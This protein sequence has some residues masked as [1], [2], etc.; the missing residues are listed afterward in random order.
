MDG[1][2]LRNL[3][4][5]YILPV[6][7]EVPEADRD[8]VA[9][10]VAYHMV[11]AKHGDFTPFSIRLPAERGRIKHWY[12]VSK[13]T[14]TPLDVTEDLTD[15]KD[16]KRTPFTSVNPSPYSKAIWAKVYAKRNSN[17]I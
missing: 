14:G 7:D 3:L 10:E 8:Y 11:G 12:L 9:A 1:E 16:G 2:K 5:E 13:Y 6:L 4:R 17:E 15:Y